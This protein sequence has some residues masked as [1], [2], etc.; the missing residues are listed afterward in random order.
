MFT[1]REELFGC[2]CV[3]GGEASQA[4]RGSRNLLLWSTD[5]VGPR[6]AGP[7]FALAYPIQGG[8]GLA[9]TLL[10]NADGSS[11]FALWSTM[12]QGWWLSS[13]KTTGQ[14][15]KWPLLLTLKSNLG[16]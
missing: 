7:G 13:A 16:G 14:F 3:A 2:L 11:G 5:N 1:S 12:S 9:E 15:S 8:P 10:E 4:A 6:R